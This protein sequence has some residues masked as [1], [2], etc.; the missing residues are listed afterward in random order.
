MQDR[1]LMVFAL[2]HSEESLGF[3]PDRPWIRK[4][5]LNQLPT[6]VENKN[7]MAENRIFLTEETYFE[8]CPEYVGVLTWQYDMK[9]SWLLPYSE[10][11]EI[12]P[13]LSPETA[14]G[15]EFSP[16][17][18][19]EWVDYTISYHKT[20]REYLDDL[21]HFAGLPLH[22]SPSFWANNFICHKSVFFDYIRLFKR[23]HAKMQEK[24]GNKFAYY[25]ED[26]RRVPAYLYER[27]TM[28]YF[29]NR[30]DLTLK[31]IP[32]RNRFIKDVCW[33][34]SAS[35]T[36]KPLTDTYVSSLKDMGVEFYMLDHIK[37]FLPRGTP[38]SIQ[39]RDQA[40]R[41]STLLKIRF[42]VE[43]LGKKVREGHN[44]KFFVFSDCDVQFFPK[45]ERWWRSLLRQVQES[46]KSCWWAMEGP[47]CVNTGFLLFKAEKAKEVLDFYR[48]VLARM[49]ETPQE[50]MPFMDQSVIN[51][52]KNE[53]NYGI[54]PH[55]HC[56]LGDRYVRET[57]DK[58]IFHHAINTNTA[59]EKIEQ[60]RK[61]RHEVSDFKDTLFV[62]KNH[63]QTEK[64]L[65]SIRSLRHFMPFVNVACL[66]LYDESQ[67]EYDEYTGA[68]EDLRTNTLF[69]KKKHADKDCSLSGMGFHV[70]EYVNRIHRL[71]PKR[72]RV[73][74]MDES[75]YFL[76]GE[77][78]RF[79]M[80]NPWDLCYGFTFANNLSHEYIPRLPLQ[81]MSHRTIAIN[82]AKFR[83]I[84]PLPEV[85]E[86][87]AII[88]GYWL[89]ET[90]RRGKMK[91]HELRTRNHTNYEGDGTFTD[92]I[93]EMRERMKV[94][95]II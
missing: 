27:L 62:Y 87:P 58:A 18:I 24:H 16:L 5:D 68:F 71:F 73:V 66:N 39:F 74:I 95:G 3:I 45:R 49:S 61:V 2:G 82:M 10:L 20:I 26:Q 64:V 22:N 70:A 76:T 48:R 67:S 44:H 69:F 37:H 30:F 89:I 77:T 34:S 14:F 86:D 65:L 50:A 94:A 23:V 4:T 56:I 83:H 72:E 90:A 80:D 84:F 91:I 54:I 38:G 60:L 88:L 92:N 32:H 55:E 13:E 41:E 93:E 11:D 21:A 31:V 8:N 17:H 63:R 7:D 46:E 40:Y 33:M 25:A 75:N 43:S 35:E 29:S 36:Y 9:Y 79:L 85:P 78:L 19:S 59:E 47:D 42:F 15:A 81:T 52:M 57:S 1:D 53:A 51:D 28:L 6:C 12:L